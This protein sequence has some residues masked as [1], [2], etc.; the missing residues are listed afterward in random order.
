MKKTN[1][2]TRWSDKTKKKKA[3]IGKKEYR[4][5]KASG[6]DKSLDALFT[7]KSEARR[8][9]RALVFKVRP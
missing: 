9:A 5:L 3:I 1:S 4:N 7:I 6:I 2:R 8:I